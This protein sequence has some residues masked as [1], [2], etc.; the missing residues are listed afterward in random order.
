MKRIN[1]Q[2]GAGSRCWLFTGLA[3]WVLAF[4][5][6]SWSGAS[7]VAT[8]RFLQVDAMAAAE[9]GVNQVLV[10]A[11]QVREVGLSSSASQLHAQAMRTRIDACCGGSCTAAH[12]AGNAASDLIG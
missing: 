3:A 12:A 6:R 11:A 9:Q 5:G 10:L 7:N 2:V 4:T 8:R 1:A